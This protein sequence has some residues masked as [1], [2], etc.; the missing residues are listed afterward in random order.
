MNRK[1]PLSLFF[2]IMSWFS[3]ELLPDLPNAAGTKEETFANSR[4]CLGLAKEQRGDS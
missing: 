4:L 3:L 2:Q 1:V